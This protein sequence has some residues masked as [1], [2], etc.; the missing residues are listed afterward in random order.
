MKLS[1]GKFARLADGCAVGEIGDTSVMVTAVSKEKQSS[2]SFLPLIVDYRQKAAAAG[3]IPTNFLRRELGPSEHEILTSRLIDR[4]LRPLF[5]AGFTNDTHIM[6]NLLAVDGVN[7]PDIVSINAASA[8]L[9]L[10]DIPWNGPIGAVRV[11]MVGE[12]LVVN[13]TRRELANS[14]LN[15]IVVA[16]NQN[17]VVMLEGGANNILQQDFCK[18]IKFGVRECQ[19][20]VQSL[21]Q[22]R[23]FGKPKRHF[24]QPEPW[25]EQ[26]VD[27]IKLIGESKLREIFL[28]TS[29]DK[30]SRDNAV[31]AV[32]AEILDKVKT[33]GVPSTPDVEMYCSN[34]FDSMCKNVIR[35]LVLEQNVRLDLR[36]YLI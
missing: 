10:S 8:A 33:G 18:A 3:R 28:D 29:H 16:A 24:K 1:Q 17:L 36:Y 5:P 32:K 31:K 2:P 22:L 13:P 34:I 23:K 27:F 9:M 6:C 35:S 4:S 20:V 30:M 7:D 12:N 26:V 21:L 15:L 25:D 19:A 14:S 11:G